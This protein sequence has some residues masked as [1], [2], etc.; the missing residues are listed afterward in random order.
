MR[1]IAMFIIFTCQGRVSDAVPKENVKPSDG[2]C[3]DER[4]L[5]FSS[6]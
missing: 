3:R 2:H 6:S 1:G 4:T 5:P